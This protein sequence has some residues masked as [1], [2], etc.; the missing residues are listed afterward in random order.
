M[1]FGAKDVARHA[2]KP[3][4]EQPIM[5]GATGSLLLRGGILMNA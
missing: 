1:L 4:R 5:A 2:N 3:G